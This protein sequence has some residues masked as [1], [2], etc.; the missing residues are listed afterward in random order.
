MS[1]LL[2]YVHTITNYEP[3]NTHTPCLLREPENCI[4]TKIHGMNYLVIN[5]AGPGNRWTKWTTGRGRTLP[6]ASA[7]PTSRRAEQTFRGWERKRNAARTDK[8]ADEHVA[9]KWDNGGRG[10]RWTLSIVCLIVCLFILLY[11][12]FGN[13][14]K[15]SHMHIYIYICLASPIEL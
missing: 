7:T 10:C 14:R 6:G 5:F 1:P 9:G 12:S 8:H 2:T 13:C 11:V 3:V 4:A 15:E